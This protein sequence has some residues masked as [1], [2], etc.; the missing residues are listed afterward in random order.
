M[1]F[2]TI[3]RIFNK[4]SRDLPLNDFDEVDVIE[5]TGEALAAIR[6]PRHL[7]EA[8]IFMD[9]KNFQAELP[10]NFMYLIQI[11]KNTMVESLADVQP[12]EEDTVIT[13]NPLES[14]TDYP[15][16][17]DCNGM[18]YD[19]YSV[20]YY[21][22]YYD[23]KYEYQFWFNTNIYRRCYVPVRLATGSFF[24]TV[25]CSEDGLDCGYTQY[26]DIENNGLYNSREYEYNIIQNKLLRFNFEKGVIAMAYIRSVTDKDGLPLIPDTYSATTAIVK[27]ITM[28]VMEKLFYLGKEGASQKLQMAKADW[29]WYARQ[30]KNEGMIP[31]TVDEY[32]N[33]MNQTN[34]MIPRRRVYDNYF[35]NLNKKEI[36]NIMRTARRNNDN[37]YYG[38]VNPGYYG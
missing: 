24:N 33:L 6:T 38:R 21:R 35:G 17:L 2:T 16:C 18:P 22:P 26:A 12:S 19:E 27:Y 14:E 5:W 8:V 28:K 11:A 36:K 9:V 15:V 20:A 13:T 29:N 30:A 7:E 3:D 23:L 34:Y 10:S 25:V 31:K 32:E 37:T 1:E 4:L